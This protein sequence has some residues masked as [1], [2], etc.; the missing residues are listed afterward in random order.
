MK[1]LCYFLFSII[2][3]VCVVFLLIGKHHF[4]LGSGLNGLQVFLILLLAIL[5]RLNSG[6]DWIQKTFFSLFVLLFLNWGITR[7]RMFH[8]TKHFKTTQNISVLSYN[9]FFKNRH[10]QN[11]VDE[12]LKTDSDVVLL[13]ELTPNWDSTLKNKIYSKY[14]YKKKFVHKGTHGLAILSKYPILSNDYIKYKSSLPICQVVK[15]KFSG[16]EVIVSNVHFASPA[17]AVENPENFYS[18]YNKNYKLRKKQ[19]EYLNEYLN[20]KYPGESKIIA[21]DLNTMR[22]E[23]L[24]NDMRSKWSDLHVKKGKGL[25]LNFPNVR[26]IPFPIITLDYILYQDEIKPSEFKILKGSSSDHLAIYGELRI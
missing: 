12:I 23:P 14:K 26:S 15:I 9:L 4:L 2:L 18:L 22:I 7:I 6:W 19:W 25:G 1:R 20:E 24:Y 13:Q 10:H 3:I 21:G 11:I 16:K 17:S 8:F 5:L